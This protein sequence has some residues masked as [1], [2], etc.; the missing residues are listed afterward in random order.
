MATIQD[1][2]KR[3][4]V[5][6][7]TVSRF[8]NNSGYCS[9]ETRARVEVAIAELGYIPNRLASGLR[10]KRTNTLAL[11]LT[12][13]TN[14]FFTTIA[15]G[16]EDTA[17]DAGYTVIFCNTDESISKEQ[18]Y[19]R[20][21]LEQRVDGIV[22]VPALSTDDFVAFVQ[23]HDTPIV[24][25]DRRISGVKADVVR[26]D[27]E[28]GAYELTRLLIS[29]GHRHIAIL[30]GPKGTSTAEDRVIGSKRALKEA[31]LERSSGQEYYGFFTQASGSEMTRQALLTSTPKP[32]ALFAA[33]NFIAIGA[34]KALRELGVRVPE[35]VAVVSFDDLPT[36]L[37]ISPFF[38]VAAQPAYEMG[39]KA[40]ELLL[41]RLSQEPPHEFKEIIL[42]AEIVIRQSS[43]GIIG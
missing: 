17:S 40:T 31:N 30:S 18:N 4:G 28:K 34:M 9:Q 36:G 35:D 26:C 42:P 6:P 13:I 7:I 37:I 19:L 39:C 24:I 21:L 23:E 12:D 32:T 20:L 14:P 33:N 11:I 43:G 38:T 3:A 8:I 27:S 16:V 2:A 22:L 41:A 5:A 25:L 10:S 1:V 29:L 15:R